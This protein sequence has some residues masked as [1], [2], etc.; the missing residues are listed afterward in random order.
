MEPVY[1]IWNDVSVLLANTPAV[2]NSARLAL[3]AAASSQ[4]PAVPMSSSAC[5]MGLAYVGEN[6]LNWS[7]SSLFL[8][9]NTGCT[10]PPTSPTA[11]HHHALRRLACA[12][13]LCTAGHQPSGND[14]CCAAVRLGVPGPGTRTPSILCGRMQRR[15][16]RVLPANGLLDDVSVDGSPARLSDMQTSRWRGSI[17][18]RGV[19]SDEV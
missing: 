9:T 18:L 19:S 1:V 16:A 12:H 8:H 6:T 10:W 2:F 14:C 7:R 4:S 3:L 5:P 15:L 11:H 17:A 13:S